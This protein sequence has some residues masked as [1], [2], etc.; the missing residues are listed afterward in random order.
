MSVLLL[1]ITTWFVVGR[2]CRKIYPATMHI[3]IRL[4]LNESSPL[5]LYTICISSCLHVPSAM[6]KRH[7]SARTVKIASKYSKLIICIV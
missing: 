5:N 3:A 1:S 7:I 2:D 4:S 6:P